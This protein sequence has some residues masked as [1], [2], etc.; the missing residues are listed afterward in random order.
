M[1]PA[2]GRIF[3]GLAVVW[4]LLAP[5]A[6]AAQA[7]DPAYPAAPEADRLTGR[8]GSYVAVLGPG[9]RLLAAAY[10]IG[11]QTL[12]AAHGIW[13][14][15]LVPGP[16]ALPMTDR[17]LLP[18]MAVEPAILRSLR[19]AYGAVPPQPDAEGRSAPAAIPVEILATGFVDPP[20]PVATLEAI[21]QWDGTAT[22]AFPSV[23]P[24][25]ARLYRARRL[26]HAADLAVRDR[27][28]E[29]LARAYLPA[30]D[31]DLP[32]TA[33]T[34]ATDI[35][36]GEALSSSDFALQ[37]WLR[38]EPE[39]AVRDCI[40]GMQAQED[41]RAYNR[42]FALLELRSVAVLPQGWTDVLAYGLEDYW[43]LEERHGIEA[44]FLRCFG[45]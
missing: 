23:G 4:L 17:G 31:L 38:T 27:D 24:V 36:A 35:L 40:A 20:R 26:P 43:A 21:F 11:P 39:P 33:W 30:F 5:L 45:Q 12:L 14:Q 10:W 8:P 29:A 28:G 15:G 13:A 16:S 1:L 37:V 41:Y 9:D 34:E 18:R 44:A 2:P 7:D 32:M 6:A 22:R 3:S 25:T 42:S 19:Y